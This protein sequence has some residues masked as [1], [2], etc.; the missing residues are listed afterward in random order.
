MLGDSD[1]T[2]LGEA[3]RAV[4]SGCLPWTHGCG[5]TMSDVLRVPKGAIV[6]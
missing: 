4:G 1:M 2:Q 6:L 3:S 5:R